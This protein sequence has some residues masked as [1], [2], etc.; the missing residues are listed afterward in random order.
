MPA[1]A[2]VV[3]S[4][5][6]VN[7]ENRACCTADGPHEVL[8]LGHDDRPTVKRVA[9]QVAIWRLTQTDVIDVLADVASIVQQP[10]QCWRQLG[11]DQEAHRVYEAITTA[12][13]AWAA[14]YARHTLMSSAVRC[15]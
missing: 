1:V 12:W 15:G 4:V 5:P 7:S 14:A 2:A 10:R 9:P 3:G 13:S 11:V 8:I 6:P